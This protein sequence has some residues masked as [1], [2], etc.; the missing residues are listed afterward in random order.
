MAP[1]PTTHD[2]APAA[3]IYHARTAHALPQCH[4]VNEY[5]P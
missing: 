5:E 2:R 3:R 4:L 1:A